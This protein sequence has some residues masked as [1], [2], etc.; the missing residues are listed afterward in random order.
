MSSSQS[1][2]SS[3]VK[4]SQWDALQ[5]ESLKAYGW[6]GDELL[7]RLQ[8]GD[9]PEDTSKFK[10]NYT[11]LSALA[12]SEPEVVESA[13]GQGYRIKFNTLRGLSNWIL[14][15]LSHEPEVVAE[16]GK[17]TVIATL[18][19]EQHQHL[20]TALSPGWTVTE[21]GTGDHGTTVYHI[22]PANRL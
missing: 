21:A 22:E 2:A 6:S 10:F 16:P 12:K 15:A 9:L 18:S 17:E 19:S 11:E 8:S 1:R 7:R 20:L 4:L 13:I 5:L 14:L 3:L